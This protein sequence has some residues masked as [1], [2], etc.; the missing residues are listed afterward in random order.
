MA[1]RNCPRWRASTN[2]TYGS[3]WGVGAEADAQA[4]VRR[5]AFFPSHRVS[6]KFHTLT[7]ALSFTIRGMRA[8]RSATLNC[9]AALAKQNKSK[10]E[11][12]RVACERRLRNTD[13]CRQVEVAGPLQVQQVEVAH[14]TCSIGI[15]QDPE[16]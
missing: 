4:G 12:M 6:H 15:A 9:A 10:P 8:E 14:G 3:P 13:S 2:K 1:Q 11:R 7:L 5:E 16:H